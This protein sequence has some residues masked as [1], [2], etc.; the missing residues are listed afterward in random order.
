MLAVD[1]GF[2]GRALTTAST[3]WRDALE[4]LL[5][6]DAERHAHVIVPGLGDQADGAGLGLQGGLE[7][8]IVGRPSARRAWSCR[9]R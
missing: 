2:R 7:A 1:H 8:R 9:R 4:V 5:V 6:A 3:D